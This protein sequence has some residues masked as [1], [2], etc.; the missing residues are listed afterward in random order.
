MNQKLSYSFPPLLSGRPHT[1]I[2]GTMPGE[3]SIE[4]G[5]YYAHPQNQFWR[6]IGDVCGMPP[7]LSYDE[8]ALF[9]TRNGIAVWDVVH[10]CRRAGSMDADIKEEIV[11]DFQSFFLEY[12][13]IRRV[14]FDSLKAEQ[15]YNRHVLPK[16]ANALEYARIPS[17]SPAYAKMRYAEKL[18][19]WRQILKNPVDRR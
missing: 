18:A 9:L 13:S 10:S 2:L 16:L 7:A 11:N 4:A 5:Q 15:L 17:P 14:V 1:L 8:R 3:K 6:L 12:P 19:V